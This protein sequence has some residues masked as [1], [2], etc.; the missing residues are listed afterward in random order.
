MLQVLESIIIMF[1]YCFI[2]FHYVYIGYIQPIYKIIYE[3][4]TTDKYINNI[5]IYIYMNSKFK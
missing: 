4:N 5:H 3:L 2:S 1:F